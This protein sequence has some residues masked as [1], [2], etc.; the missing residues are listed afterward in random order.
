M[1]VP[2]AVTLANQAVQLGL[3]T[4][5]H[6]QD[7]WDELGRKAGTGEEFVRIMERKGH[8]TPWQ[9]SKLLKGERDG[10][11]LGGYRILYRIS[12]G[13]FGRVYRADDPHSGKVVAVKVLRNRWNDNPHS[14][15]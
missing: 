12:S 11:F 7:A 15:E 9:T 4:P 8:L 3:L 6:V 10:Y 14:V 13:S 2:D 1:A 5:E